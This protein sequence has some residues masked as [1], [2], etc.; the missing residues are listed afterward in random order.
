MLCWTCYSQARKNWWKMQKSRASHG[1]SGHETVELK[2]Q[3]AVSKINRITIPDFRRADLGLFGDLLGKI[4]WETALE[5][6]GAQGSWVILKNIFLRAQEWFSP[7]CRSQTQQKAGVDEQG[8]VDQA[9][10]Q[11]KKYTE[12]GSRG[13][14]LGR[15]MKT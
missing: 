3:R 4:P 5:G 10:T 7:V 8:A 2:I 6:K 12:G 9:Q 1:F 13:R 15:N 14:Q 11:K